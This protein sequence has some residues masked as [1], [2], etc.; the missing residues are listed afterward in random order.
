MNESTVVHGHFYQ[1]PREN[2]WL[3]EVEPEPGAAPFANWNERIVYECYQPFGE[4]RLLDAQGHVTGTVNLYEWV[5]FDFAPTLL[6]WMERH[7]VDTYQRILAADRASAARLDGHGNAIASPF[8]HVILPLASRRDKVTEVRWGLADFRRRFG[9]DAEGF[10]LPEAAADEETLVVL[11]EEGV[12]FTL[13]APQQAENPDHR[14]RPLR[15]DAGGGRELAV[16]TWDGPL[17]HAIAFGHLLRSGHD[18]AHA[19]A[20]IGLPEY[21]F[22]GDVQITSVAT[23]GETFG[24]HHKFSE[25]ALARAFDLLRPQKRVRIENFAS[26]LARVPPVAPLILVE[27]SSWSCAHGVERWRSGC[28]CGNDPT[29]SHAWRRPL[30]SALNWLGR[31]LDARYAAEAAGCF[32][33]PWAV[34]DAYSEVASLG[35]AKRNAFIRKRLRKGADAAHARRLLDGQRARLGMFS[36]CAWFFDS[37]TGHETTLM[38]RMAASAIDLFRAH[39]LEPAFIERLRLVTDD[40]KSDVNAASVYQTDVLRLRR[41]A[42]THDG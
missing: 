14:G 4:A 35:D 32:R 23:D 17:A 33:D 36:S 21:G 39:D 20:P 25:M 12:R 26:V 30:R 15:F 22:G 6:M 11:A 9:R 24:H 13:L 29:A 18:L 41:V 3:G 7:A 31:E 1:P 42:A 16:F 8:H 37:A 34:R 10:W 2:P 27:P 19:I 28:P 5:S 40:A 38:L